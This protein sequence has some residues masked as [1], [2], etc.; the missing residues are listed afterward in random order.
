[1]T[2]EESRRCTGR[3]LE[4]PHLGLWPPHPRQDRPRP[5]M[6][7]PYLFGQTHLHSLLLE[8]QERTRCFATQEGWTRWWRW[9]PGW[10]TP[11]WATSTGN[12]QRPQLPQVDFLWYASHALTPPLQGILGQYQRTG[13]AFQ[14]TWMLPSPGPMGKLIS[15]KG[16]NIGASRPLANWTAATPSRWTRASVESRQTWML[17]WSGRRTI[18]STS[19][20]DPNTGSLTLTGV[21]II[22]NVDIIITIVIIAVVM[23]IMITIVIIMIILRSPPVD[24]SYPRPIS[25]WEVISC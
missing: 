5:S 13:A 20:K 1:M 11:S 7:L 6:T 22:I 4:P 24:S 18:R 17:P 21:I 8:E 12:S 16:Q 10:P 25:N 14:G 15:S 2:C 9:R 19:S 3:K 23:I